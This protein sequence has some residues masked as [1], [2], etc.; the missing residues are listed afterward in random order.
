MAVQPGYYSDWDGSST[1][2]VRLL[3]HV[4]GIYDWTP[5][6]Q[7]VLGA[8]YLDR[9][10]IEVL[11][12]AGFIWKPDADAEYRVVFPEPKISWCIDRRPL[13]ERRHPSAVASLSRRPSTGSTLPASSAVGLGQSV[14][15]TA[16]SDLMSYSDWRVFLGLETQNVLK[17]PVRSSKSAT[18]SI[19]SSIFPARA[20]TWTS[21]IR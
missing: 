11:P 6:F 5:T 10:D 19:A 8:A 3:G 4:S 15:A 18:S 2:A 21:A 9:P 14:T 20:R 12:I 13:S 17:C 1:R 16:A 7:L